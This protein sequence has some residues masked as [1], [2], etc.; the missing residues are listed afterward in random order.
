[1]YTIN[2]HLKEIL[3]KNH[4]MIQAFDYNGKII[5]FDSSKK[6]YI[7]NHCEMESSKS[8]PGHTH[9][10]MIYNTTL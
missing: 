10:S 7:V 1:M 6:G 5:T 4:E 8:E 2:Y 9:E 3:F